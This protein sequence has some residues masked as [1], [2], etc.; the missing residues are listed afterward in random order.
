MKVTRALLASLALACALPCALPSAAAQDAAAVDKPVDKPA[1]KTS[2]TS[3]EGERSKE[4]DR[5]E[6][7]LAAVMDELVEARA[8]AGVIARGLFQTELGVD[9]VRRADDQRLSH[10]RL[11]LDGV[12]VHDSDGSAL[13]HDRATLFTGYVAP[14][15]HELGIELVENAK[16]GASFGYTR[17]ERY[18]IEVKKGR[19]TRVELVLR[20]DSDMAEEAAEG[21]HGEYQLQTSVRVSSKP[22]AKKARD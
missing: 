22:S 15:F 4:L 2:A 3:N 9:V 1:D 13:G 21:D 6:Q 5:L 14:G 12:P 11:T 20:D 16:E 17:S 19:S 7:E 10:L 18:R 8:R